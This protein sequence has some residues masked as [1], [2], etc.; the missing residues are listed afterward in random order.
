LLPVLGAAPRAFVRLDI[1]VGDLDGDGPDP[2][3]N[4]GWVKPVGRRPPELHLDA[5]RVTT[6]RDGSYPR[7]EPIDEGVKLHGACAEELIYQWVDRNGSRSSLQATPTG[8]SANLRDHI[9]LSKAVLSLSEA[10]LLFGV[11]EAKLSL[12]AG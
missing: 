5:R 9:D 8:G 2:N 3:W 10:R 1:I 12:G 4:V 6:D 7:A 11:D